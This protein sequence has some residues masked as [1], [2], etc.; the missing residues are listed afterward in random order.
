MVLIYV[1]K[2]SPRLQYIC[3]F[4][5]KELIKAPYA[6][7]SHLD[8][9]RNFDG[10]KINYSEET[11]SDCF[12]IPNNGFLYELGIREQNI[13]VFEFD[14]IKGFFKHKK[15]GNRNQPDI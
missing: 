2:T 1:D 5:F 3:S 8:S 11:I 6:I 4:I 12:S 10:I 14:G 9:F 7:T 13:H 15:P